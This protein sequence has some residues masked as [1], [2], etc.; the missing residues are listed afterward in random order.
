[1]GKDAH[2]VFISY[3]SEDRPAAERLADDLRELDIDC[4]LDKEDLQAGD[5][6]RAK[7][8]KAVKHAPFFFCLLSK[9]GA[10]AVQHDRFVAEE[11]RQALE[12]QGKRP[13]GTRYFIPLKLEDCDYPEFPQLR[14]LHIHPLFPDWEKSIK[15]LFRIFLPSSK[16]EDGPA[17]I[18]GL[19]LG[20]GESCVAMTT[21]QSEDEPS[22]VEILPGKS[23]IITSVAIQND[24][25]VIGDE[26]FTRQ[27]TSDFYLLFK[28]DRLERK[29]VYR[30][31]QLFVEAIVDKLIDGGRIRDLERSLFVVG[32]PSGWIGNEKR[33]A[34]FRRILQEAGL[35]RVQI[36]PESRGAFLDLRAKGR[37]AEG[38]DKF[39]EQVL[40]IDVGSSTTDFTY[41]TNREE[42]P[43]DEGHNR[44][45]AGLFDHE[46][47]RLNLERL[48]A[49]ELKKYRR[50][51]AES[52]E[53]EP[54]CLLKCRRLK[55]DLF[56]RTFANPEP[57]IESKDFVEVDDDLI[58]RLRL[59]SEEL[60]ELIDRPLEA[61][62][63]R[64]WRKEFIN[65]L[66][67][68][69]KKHPAPSLIC[70]TG[71]AS[72]MGFV[73]EETERIFSDPTCEILM[74]T[75]PEYTVAKG[76]A[77]AGKIDIQVEH[78]RAECKTYLESAA[79][80]D[81]L[82]LLMKQHLSTLYDDFIESLVDMIMAK[83]DEWKKERKTDFT[84]LMKQVFDRDHFNQIGEEQLIGKL[85]TFFE[86]VKESIK[87]FALN[88]A[89]KYKIPTNN[90]LLFAAELEEL[91]TLT[92]LDTLEDDD[93][94]DMDFS[95]E[96]KWL[97]NLVMALSEGLRYLLR[98]G[99]V[100]RAVRRK[101]VDMMKA[102]LAKDQEN[103][104]ADLKELGKDLQSDIHD[105]LLEGA[106]EYSLLI[107]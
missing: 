43:L 64:S 71:G 22:V 59:R 105:R 55:E 63:G 81:R 73:R 41:V 2:T 21:L 61:L 85:S 10:S 16:G 65:T 69:K 24:R 79:F 46:I 104:L 28:S 48:P 32:C 62:N 58:L 75:E 103:P 40:I 4:W 86:E 87:P 94:E 97:R 57:S 38:N 18:F 34:H 47:L 35:P 72:R 68:V 26:A 15:R 37:L 83:V 49:G 106:E 1:M 20:H 98:V 88:L 100:K 101:L 95:E 102:E 92:L 50:K 36:I 44:L 42:R 3:A 31:I 76:L 89:I 25:L 96:P 60:R 33:I 90:Q 23:S 93:L 27:G 56:T 107:R 52:P 84:H 51:C 5:N 19:D 8:A 39:Q 82:E 78:F 54:Q 66:R 14:D 29:E 80:R 70:I 91:K 12:E 67:R 77:K 9:N 13:F 53:F 7:I 74:G 17:E 6:W 45:G 30:P 11:I 99:F